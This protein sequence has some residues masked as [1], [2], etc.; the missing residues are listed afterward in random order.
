M[1]P[2]LKNNLVSK[3]YNSNGKETIFKDKIEDNFPK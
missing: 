2:P 3:K 1:L